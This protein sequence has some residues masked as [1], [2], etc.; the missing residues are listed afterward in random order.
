MPCGKLLVKPGAGFQPAGNV[1]SVVPGG[2]GTT[3]VFVPL[4]GVLFLEH[5][6]AIVINASNRI[7]NFFITQ[8]IFLFDFKDSK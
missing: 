8:Y 7:N 3:G 2:G 6:P 4:P 5:E 1:I